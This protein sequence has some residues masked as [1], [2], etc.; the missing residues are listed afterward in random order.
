M[1]SE[2]EERL[3]LYQS[4]KPYREK[5]SPRSILTPMS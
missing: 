3:R 4:G 2:L 1:I 5:P